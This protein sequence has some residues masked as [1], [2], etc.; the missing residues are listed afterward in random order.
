MTRS[1]E[2]RTACSKQ[3][4][5]GAARLRGTRRSGRGTLAARQPRMAA[6]LSAR[7]WRAGVGR[8][9]RARPAGAG[10]TGRAGARRAGTRGRRGGARGD[11]CR[12]RG[13]EAPRQA[14]GAARGAAPRAAVRAADG[15]YGAGGRFP[16]AENRNTCALG[17]GAS[18]VGGSACARRG[19]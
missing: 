4:S 13:G 2:A 17:R 3:G 9:G 18:A 12:S 8:R 6:L 7:A 1:R 10:Q 5:G 16:D 14:S 19:G 11:T 15:T